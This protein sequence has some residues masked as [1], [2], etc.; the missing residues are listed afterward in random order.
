MCS[1]HL[2][3]DLMK[4]LFQGIFPTQGLNLGLL[5]YRWIL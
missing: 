4:T 3:Y 1:V 2:M 5:N